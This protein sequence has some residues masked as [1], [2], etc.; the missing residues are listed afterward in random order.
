MK[1][2]RIKEESREY[3]YGPGEEFE[4][5]YKAKQHLN[6]MKNQILGEVISQALMATIED[7]KV[8]KVKDKNAYKLTAV[9]KYP[10]K[11]FEEQEENRTWRY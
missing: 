2:E 8:V 11:L 7:I 5:E 3:K 10:T 4:T 9:I 6:H 1:Y